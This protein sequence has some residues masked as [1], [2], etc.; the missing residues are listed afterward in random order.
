MNIIASTLFVIGIL[1][2]VF[3]YKREKPPSIDASPTSV[4]PLIMSVPLS[5]PS[6]VKEKWVP[7]PEPE[8]KF[9]IGDAV[10]INFDD[11]WELPLHHGHI[12]NRRKFLVKPGDF[13]YAGY[14][15][16]WVIEYK[17]SFS[18]NTFFESNLRP[19]DA[20]K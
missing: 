12:T 4:N 9:K 15:L 3:Y 7:P 6:P 10:L 11:N 1:I 5:T 8:Y 20:I 17:V 14:E 18:E 16:G 13:Y 2:F 19:F